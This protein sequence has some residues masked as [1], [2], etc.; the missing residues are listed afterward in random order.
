[1]GE[2]V[3]IRHGE[4]EWSRT[5]RHTGLTDLPLTGEGERQAGALRPLLAPRDIGRVVTSPLLRA[6]RTAELA[7]LEGAVTDPDL[8]EWD[9]GGYEGITTADI[10]RRRPGWYLWRDGIV[11]GGPGHPGESVEEVGERVDRVLERVDPLVGDDAEPDVV[12]VAH[13]H[14]LRVLTAR[15][16][17]L[18]PASGALFTLATGAVSTLGHEHGRHALTSWNVPSP[19]AP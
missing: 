4:T 17:G 19:S 7:G 15:W 12:L 5:R 11:P 2:L 3:L 6:V 13:S 16:L 1:M 10:R 8:T 9:Y 18:P 14:L